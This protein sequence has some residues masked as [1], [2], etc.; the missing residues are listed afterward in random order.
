M[1]EDELKQ[2][3]NKV[4]EFVVLG[5]TRINYIEQLYGLIGEKNRMIMV[6]SGFYSMVIRDANA[7]LL[8]SIRKLTETR[9]D[10]VNITAL[11]DNMRKWLK[12]NRPEV[13]GEVNAI[14]VE[15]EKARGAQ[16]AKDAMVAA[17]T[18]AAHHS[19][20]L[21]AKPADVKY[22]EARDWLLEIGGLLNGVS[23]KLWNS[24]TVLEIFDSTDDSFAKEMRHMERA[25]LSGTQ[26]LRT[27]DTHLAVQYADR[28]I[29]K[30]KSA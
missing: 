8:I 23:G 1:T 25:E 5:V 22:A 28:L 15:I 7:N 20:K 12:A 30:K 19:R 26:L 10:T 9:A 13:F 24:S 2:E 17:S 16:V 11:I 6:H 4:V 27:D 14:L 3:F 29:A 18:V 21:P